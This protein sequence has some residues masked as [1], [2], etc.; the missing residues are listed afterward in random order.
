M[1]L[2]VRGN[3]FEP[4]GIWRAA[5]IAAAA[6]ITLSAGITLVVKA[7]QSGDEIQRWDDYNDKQKG[8][9]TAS[10]TTA[11]SGALRLTGQGTGSCI[12]M[13]RNNNAGDSCCYV[14]Q[15]GTAWVCKAS[16]CSSNCE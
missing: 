1:A 13:R 8:V 2:N 10:G 6:L 16:A 15:A 14:D 11:F 5:S 3:I 12:T 7:G 9:I 4:Q